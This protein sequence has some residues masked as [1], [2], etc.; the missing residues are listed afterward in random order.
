MEWYDRE[1]APIK[2]V[3]LLFVA[4][5]LLLIYYNKPFKNEDYNNLCLAY[6]IFIL[7]WLA[8][9]CFRY[10]YMYMIKG[11]RSKALHVELP[12]GLKCLFNDSDCKTA[13]FAL[14]SIFHIL[15]YLI[16]GYYIPDQY[17]IIIAVSF[18][19]EFLEYF[20]GFQAKFV[21]DPVINTLSYLV[22]SLLSKI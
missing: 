10:V 1:F 17:V 9:I 2:Q 4:L 8:T 18:L 14:F 3:F 7:L 12:Y 19:C 16:I 15:G 5:F 11:S 21:L 6:A 22:G 20:M 13:D